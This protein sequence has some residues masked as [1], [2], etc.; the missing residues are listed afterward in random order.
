MFPASSALSANVCDLKV[1]CAGFM[2][3]SW[4][5]MKYNVNCYVF[6]KA[7]SPQTNTSR[8]GPIF[9]RLLALFWSPSTPEKNGRLCAFVCLLFHD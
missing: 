9:T 5:K 7:L 4:Q 2:Q 8:V 3:L 1:Q 6:I